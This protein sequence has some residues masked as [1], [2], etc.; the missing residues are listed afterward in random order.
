MMQGLPVGVQQGR[1][2]GQGE[3]LSEWRQSAPYDQRR[4]QQE[5]RAELIH[6]A[7]RRDR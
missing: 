4:E 5:G 6:L 2:S 1:C 7:L 3:A